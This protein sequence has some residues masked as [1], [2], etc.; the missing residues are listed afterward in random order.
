MQT[1]QKED[2][3]FSPTV[4][5][6]LSIPLSKWHYHSPGCLSQTPSHYPEFLSFPYTS[7]PSHLQSCWPTLKMYPGFAH[8]SLLPRPLPSG[9]IIISLLDHGNS[10][11][12]GLLVWTLAARAAVHG[13]SGCIL[14]KGPRAMRVPF[15]QRHIYLTWE[16]A[17]GC[18]Q[19]GFL[20]SKLESTEESLLLHKPA[21]V[22]M[23]LCTL[24]RAHT[25]R[26]THS[27]AHISGLCPA[28]ALVFPELTSLTHHSSIS[29]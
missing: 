21:P 2:L 4:F 15:F 8:F 10:L 28:Q 16:C 23:V 11:L 17:H 26:C 9:A 19:S 25:H 14:Y 12:T 5:L 29:V 6:F 18:R 7:H 1:A 13:C 22:H 3:W 27:V 24:Q 20:G